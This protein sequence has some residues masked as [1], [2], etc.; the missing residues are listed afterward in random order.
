[1]RDVLERHGLAFCIFDMP[2]LP[3]PTWVTGDAVYLRFHGSGAVYGGRYGEEA[4]RPWAG[5]ISR[6]LE[7]GQTVYVY[8]N[9]DALGCAVED[10]RTLRH[11]L[12]VDEG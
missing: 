11:L 7:Q 6:W 2:G 12:G 10:A 4:L 9:N 8:F 1:V 5:R 3:C